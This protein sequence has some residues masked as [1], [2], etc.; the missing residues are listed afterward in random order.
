[1]RKRGG[2]HRESVDPAA[3]KGLHVKALPILGATRIEVVVYPTLAWNTGRF[4]GAFDL[5]YPLLQLPSVE[6][7]T[8]GLGDELKR[9]SDIQL[10]LK[11]RK[12]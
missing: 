8:H 11:R 2:F 1:M 5:P 10:E 6:Q 4:A 3:V 9:W 12:G 7:M